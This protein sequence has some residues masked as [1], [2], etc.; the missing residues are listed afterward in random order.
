MTKCKNCSQEL[1][2]KNPRAIYC[3]DRCKT[4]YHRG[5]KN[6]NNPITVCWFCGVEFNI[7][8]R[9][10]FCS[11]EHKG[12]FHKSKE[13]DKAIVLIIDANTKIETK[14]YDKIPRI[15]QEWK[16]RRKGFLIP[17]TKI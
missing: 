1:K 7:K 14:K 9:K 13:K 4:A 16:E 15:I 10:K 2:S 11:D 17:S 12:K 6:K 8:G 3:S 5:E